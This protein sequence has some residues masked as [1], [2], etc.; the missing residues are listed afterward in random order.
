MGFLSHGDRH[1]VFFESIKTRILLVKSEGKW[2]YLSSSIRKHSIETRLSKI[3][4]TI[5]DASNT[6][7]NYRRFPT[8]MDSD[9]FIQEIVP[10]I[11]DKA[12][13]LVKALGARLRAKVNLRV[14]SKEN[15][16][17]MVQLEFR[18]A[19]GSPF[20]LERFIDH[21]SSCYIKNNGYTYDFET[22]TQ[23]LEQWVV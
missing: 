7:W 22:E 14:Y 20:Y 8:D 17:W 10:D 9:D 21:N 1:H 4:Q 13:Q 12:R 23:P 6:V 19:D 3:M 16:R 2:P 11:T 18:V 15:A 5:W